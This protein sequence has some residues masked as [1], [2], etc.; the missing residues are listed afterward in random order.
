MSTYRVRQCQNGHDV[1]PVRVMIVRCPQCRA[2]LAPDRPTYTDPKPGGKVT[3]DGAERH[4]GA[5]QRI[6]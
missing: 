6:A 4:A 2:P 1:Q 3:R 5:I